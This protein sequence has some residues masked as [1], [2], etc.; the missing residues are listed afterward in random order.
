MTVRDE[1]AVLGLAT[2]TPRSRQAQRAFRRA[3]AGALGLA[4]LAGVVAW[5]AR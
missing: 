4:G 3:V 5:V 2:P 1:L